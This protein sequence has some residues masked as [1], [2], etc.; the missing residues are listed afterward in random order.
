MYVVL[1]VLQYVLKMHTHI[2]IFYGMCY[3]SSMLLRNFFPLT[4]F[5][6]VSKATP[7]VGA[8]KSSSSSAQT[9]APKPAKKEDVVFQVTAA[10]F[11]QVVLESPVPVLLDIYADWCGP[12][13]QLV[14]IY[15]CMYVCMFLSSL[16]VGTN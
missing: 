4:F 12:C 1:F 16:S 2:I 14:R 11:Q 3:D 8:G 6:A 9:P 15:D 13:K 7:A 10:T 5:A